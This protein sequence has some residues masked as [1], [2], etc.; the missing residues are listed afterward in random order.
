MMLS[1]MSLKSI[2]IYVQ[3]KG[4]RKETQQM[5]SSRLRQ[6]RGLVSDVTDLTPPLAHA[7]PACDAMGAIAKVKRVTAGPWAGL[8]EGQETS[9][10]STLRLS[11][12]GKFSFVSLPHTANHSVT[13]A[14]TCYFIY[15]LQQ[16]THLLTGIRTEGFNNKNST[17]FAGKQEHFRI[18]HHLCSLFGFDKALKGES[19][20]YL[21]T[22]IMAL[23]YHMI[24][25]CYIQLYIK[26]YIIISR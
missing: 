7:H 11:Q 15:S 6:Y 3:N 4:E 5:L 13:D 16:G 10:Q 8:G 14:V 19:F 21:Y 17:N 25:N 24:K 26:P 18:L 1:L 20:K 22:C 9:F 12:R 23:N 2:R